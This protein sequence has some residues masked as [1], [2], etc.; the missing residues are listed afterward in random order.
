MLYT[1]F[2]MTLSNI[3]KIWIIAFHYWETE[4]LLNCEEYHYIWNIQNY[5][6]KYY[7][8]TPIETNVNLLNQTVNNS[9]LSL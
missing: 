9:L 2:I 6:R 4:K 5:S 7:N 3:A 1:F 8:L